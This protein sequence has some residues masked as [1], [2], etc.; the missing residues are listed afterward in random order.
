M[1]IPAIDYDDI[2]EEH[3]AYVFPACGHV[4][5]FHKS[6]QGRPCPLC[7][8]AGPFVP[9]AFSFEPAIDCSIPTHVFNPCG[10]VASRK[11]CE[12]WQKISMHDSAPP[13]TQLRPICPFCATALVED[14]ELGGPF[15]KLILQTESEQEWCN[16]MTLQVTPSPA[17]RGCDCQSIIHF[18]IYDRCKWLQFRVLIIHNIS[19]PLVAL[20]GKMNAPC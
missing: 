5:G 7:R 8:K 14:G 18:E 13:T 10:H 2:D 16:E 6:L 17:Y 11:T 20:R 4:H 1:H 3:R 12:E 19:I 15:N 9:I